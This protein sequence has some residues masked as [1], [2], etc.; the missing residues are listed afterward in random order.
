[1]DASLWADGEFQP[2]LSGHI[3]VYDILETVYGFL[4]LTGRTL[5]ILRSVSAGWRYAVRSIDEWA[6][7]FPCPCAMG[8]ALLTRPRRSSHPA[9]IIYPRIILTAWNQLILNL[10]LSGCDDAEL[11]LFTPPVEPATTLWRSCPVLKKLTVHHSYEDVPFVPSYISSLS[12]HIVLKCLTLETLKADFPENTGAVL[13]RCQCLEQVNLKGQLKH[14]HLLGLS[15]SQSIKTLKLASEVLGSVD[16]LSTMASLKEL[17][18]RSFEQFSFEP[19]SKM[20]SLETFDI[21]ASFVGE[22]FDAISLSKSLRTFRCKGGAPISKAVFTIP[23]LRTAELNAATFGFDSISFLAQ[24]SVR[25]L[26][27]VG[28]FVPVYLPSFGGCR[29]LQTLSIVGS[30]FPSIDGL[31][32]CLVLRALALPWNR[33]LTSAGLAPL[34]SLRTLTRLDITG[35]SLVQHLDAFRTGFRMAMLHIAIVGT[36]IPQ[37]YVKEFHTAS[38]KMVTLFFIIP[39]RDWLGCDRE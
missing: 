29:T 28:H 6:H 15:E 16:C 33:L 24:S 34:A 19:V 12:A 11:F 14:Q 35:C 17:Q 4:P 10:E 1:M 25:H 26:F 18:L 32:H 13:G 20:S 27:L 9:R 7:N 37:N 38:N 23:T 8:H 5:S 36:D 39:S 31:Q 2:P 21:E 30:L 3:L 22:G